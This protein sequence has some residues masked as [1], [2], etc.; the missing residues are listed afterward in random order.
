MLKI[1]GSSGIEKN[2]PRSLVKINGMNFTYKSRQSK[3]E[4]QIDAL[5]G[6]IYDFTDSRQADL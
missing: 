2:T 3:F 5:K 6:H 1:A 4:G